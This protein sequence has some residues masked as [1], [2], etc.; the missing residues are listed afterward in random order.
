MKILNT[1]SIDSCLAKHCPSLH[2]TDDGRVF[3]QGARLSVLE[4]SELTIPEN[5]DAVSLDV[6]VLRQLL[7][8]FKA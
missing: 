7:N 2:V 4:K 1:Y 8:K 5:E 6:A 3:V